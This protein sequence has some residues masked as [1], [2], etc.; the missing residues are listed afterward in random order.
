MCN[1]RGD[2]AKILDINH[3]ANE[4]TVEQHFFPKEHVVPL[5]GWCK[6]VCKDD[7]NVVYGN[8]REIQA[9]AMMRRYEVDNKR[10]EANNSAST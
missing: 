2:M 8:K 5:E 1:A 9:I 10:K 6:Q 7:A 4:I 3:E